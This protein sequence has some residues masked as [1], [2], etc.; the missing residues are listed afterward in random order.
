LSD[1]I[2]KFISHS[3]LT[4]LDPVLDEVELLLGNDRLGK[5]Y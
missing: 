3:E 2:T 4:F 1:K 5:L